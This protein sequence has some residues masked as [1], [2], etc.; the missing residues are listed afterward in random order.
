MASLQANSETIGPLAWL[1]RRRD[2]HGKPLISREEYEAGERLAADFHAAMLS[3]RVTASWSGA[4]SSRRQ[5]RGPPGHGVE[6]SDAVIGAKQRFHSALK[7][8]GRDHGNLLVDV[9]CFERGLTE[10]EKQSGWPQRSGKLVLQ[11]ALRQLARHYGLIMDDTG[12]LFS[13]VRAWGNE[14]YRPDL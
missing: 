14:G 4:A 10:I 3:P 8:V 1:H 13:E 6:L 9:C 5:R 12:G 11:L 2:K 7:A